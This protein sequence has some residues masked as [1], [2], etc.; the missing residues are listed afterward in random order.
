MDSG[1]GNNEVDSVERFWI[2]R[3]WE[4][5][6][7]RFQTDSVD[8]LID[9]LE[10]VDEI[11]ALAQIVD[12]QEK[13]E[14]LTSYLPAGLRVVWRNMAAYGAGHS[15]AE[16]RHAI[17]GLYP[18]ITVHE[19]GSLSVLNTLCRDAG[20]IEV[21]EEGRLRRFG[22][23]FRA[24]VAKTPAVI[25]NCDACQKYLNV[26]SPAF[27]RRLRQDIIDRKLFRVLARR[28]GVLPVAQELEPRRDDPIPLQEL[29]EIAEAL[30][31]MD[32][33]PGAT[34]NFT[35]GWEE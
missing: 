33:G 26:L 34:L 29:V 15:Y 9:F 32:V 4:K 8:T 1:K 14:L 28:A 7:P 24:L 3:T 22:L 19:R 6:V 11:F 16:F 25:T 12:Q 10:Q 31:S 21:K 13:K 35:D 27:S 20:V 18:E 30:A 5:D 2:P 23:E 17:R